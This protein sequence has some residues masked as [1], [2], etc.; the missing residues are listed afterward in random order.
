MK[1]TAVITE[2]NYNNVI[3]D[4]YTYQMFPPT[5]KQNTFIPTK[6]N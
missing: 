4:D 1:T 6:S 5:M 3:A 2:Q